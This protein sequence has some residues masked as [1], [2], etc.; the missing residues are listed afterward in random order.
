MPCSWQ[1]SGRY[2]WCYFLFLSLRRKEEILYGFLSNK[3]KIGF[4]QKKTCADREWWPP[5][6]AAEFFYSWLGLQYKSYSLD[7][8][9]LSG[10]NHTIIQIIWL[11][12]AHLLVHLWNSIYIISRVLPIF[13]NF[14][15][16]VEWWCQ[17]GLEGSF[18]IVDIFVCWTDLLLQSSKSKDFHFFLNN[19]TTKKINESI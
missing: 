19:A 14:Q 15:A 16:F 3:Q 13:Q 6:A 17:F 5:S 12:Y 4:Q 8:G 9:L 11:L 18:L 2:K 10:I 1:R 7:T